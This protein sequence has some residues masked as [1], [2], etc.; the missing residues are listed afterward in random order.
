MLTTIKEYGFSYELKFNYSPY[1]GGYVAL[2]VTFDGMK[3]KRNA[4]DVLSNGTNAR[5]GY[6]TSK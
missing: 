4:S 5:T 6:K 2:L 3:S 1:S